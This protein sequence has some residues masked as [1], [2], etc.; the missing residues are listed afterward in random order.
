MGDQVRGAVLDRRQEI[1]SGAAEV[2]S[3]F[4]YHRARMS[5]IAGTSGITGPALY[6]HFP[7]REA[8]L[9]AVIDAGTDIVDDLF[10]KAVTDG[11]E[12]ADLL[13][14]TLCGLAR[15]AVENRYFGITLQREEERRVGK[16]VDQV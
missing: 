11:G 6:R 5:Q 10:Q 9:A 12:P 2:F 7:G 16:S 4:G 13:A 15:A 1:L 14:R 3:E 8:L